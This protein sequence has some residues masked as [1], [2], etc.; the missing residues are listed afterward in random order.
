MRLRSGVGFTTIRTYPD[1]IRVWLFSAVD[2]L[3]GI[4]FLQAG[5]DR[6]IRKGKGDAFGEFLH[7]RAL[8]GVVAG[9]N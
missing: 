2:E 1:R 7:A 9:K 5:P 8:G 6:Q 3:Q 4:A